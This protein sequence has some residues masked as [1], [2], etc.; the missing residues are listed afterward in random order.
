MEIKS[1]GGTIA[2]DW[3]YPINFLQAHNHES[4]NETLK[5]CIVFPGLSGHSQKGYV[6]SLVRHLS[7]ERGYIV[8]VFHNRGVA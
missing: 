1:D 4:T 2:I 5:I 7:E 6:K 3:A 8:G